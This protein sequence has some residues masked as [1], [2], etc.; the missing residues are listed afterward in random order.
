MAVNGKK[1]IEK[2]KYFLFFNTCTKAYGTGIYLFNST[3]EIVKHECAKLKKTGK[4]L[5]I[6]M[7]LLSL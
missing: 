1:E 3:I 2:S 7:V 4:R 6:Y 5:V